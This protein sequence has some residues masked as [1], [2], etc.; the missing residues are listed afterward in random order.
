V[1]AFFLGKRTDHKIG[2]L[3]LFPVVL[4]TQPKGN[5]QSQEYGSGSDACGIALGSFMTK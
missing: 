2:I 3:L 4:V 1:I 5:A